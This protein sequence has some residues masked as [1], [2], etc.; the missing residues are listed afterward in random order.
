MAHNDDSNDCV[1]WRE[2][3]PHLDT[4][5][6]LETDMKE[7][8]TAHTEQ[9]HALREIKILLA[10]LIAVSS[11]GLVNGLISLMKSAH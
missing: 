9:N 11:P 8:R 7:V 10:V 3:R 6:E 4:L 2:I 5:K 1:T